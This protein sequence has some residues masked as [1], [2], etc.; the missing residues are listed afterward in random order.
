MLNS[1]IRTIAP[2]AWKVNSCGIMSGMGRTGRRPGPSRSREA[3]LAAARRRFAESGYDATSMRAIAAEAGVDPAVV[4]H[5]FGSKDG[6]F[7]AAVGWPFDPAGLASEITTRGQAHIAEGI[8][9]A[10]L[11]YWE[12][13]ATRASLLALLRSAMTHDASAGLLREFVVRQLF[14]H[15]VDLLDGPQ[16]DLRVSLAAAQLVGLAVLR[17]ALRVEPV[18][19][20]TTED[21]VAMLTPALAR[22]LDPGDSR[23]ARRP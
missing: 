17:Y 10:F 13:P 21:L 5:F 11:G 6:V 14:S 8:A 1:H 15:V 20:A 16:A 12:D 19:S 7:R 22:Y 4:V 9:R 3:I 23:P 2:G 18:A